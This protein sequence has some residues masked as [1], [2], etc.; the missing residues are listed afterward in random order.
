MS[1]LMGALYLVF[2]RKAE[3]KVRSFQQNIDHNMIRACWTKGRHP[4]LRLVRDLDMPVMSVRYEAFVPRSDGNGDVR[5]LVMYNG[6]ESE[7]RNEQRKGPRKLL[8][9][10]PGGGFVAMNP[11]DHE[12]YLSVWAAELNVP[13]VSVD[14]RKAP[15]DPFPAGLNDCWDVYQSLVCDSAKLVFGTP[16]EEL[17]IAVVGDS[18]GGNLAAAVT[19]MAISKPGMTVPVG[20]H[21]I[22]PALTLDLGLW[23]EGGNEVSNV[24]GHSKQAEGTGRSMA[25]LVKFMQDGVLPF[26]YM[27]Q[28]GLDYLGSPP[29]VDPGNWRVSP[30][31]APLELFRQFPDTYI[32]AG[33]ADPLI[34]ISISFL[35]KLQENNPTAKTALHILS[36]IHI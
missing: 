34:D 12:D 17:Q 30:L 25:S 3:I 15:E 21:L 24:T 2:S 11:E 18:A 9:S 19:F 27:R 31:N 14:Y 26:T 28:I 13:V 36:L 1:I 23:V 29:S 6:S 8:L 16:C 35:R 33:S 10:F 32:H 22:Y 20:V 5:V 4:L 7:L